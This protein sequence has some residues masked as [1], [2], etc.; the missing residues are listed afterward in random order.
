MY[1]IDSLAKTMSMMGE[2]GNFQVTLHP[3]GPPEVIRFYDTFRNMVSR[4]DELTD[5][6]IRAELQALQFQINPHFFR[7]HSQ[8]HPVNGYDRQE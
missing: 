3:S 7:Q 4:I 1:P 2:E 6:K 5:E 8:L